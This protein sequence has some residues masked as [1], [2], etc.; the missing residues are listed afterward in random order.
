VDQTAYIGVGANEGDRVS[1]CRRG[2]SEVSRL[3]K[4]RITRVSSLYETEPVGTNKDSPWF[5]NAVIEVSTSHDPKT[6]LNKLLEIEQKFGRVRKEGGGRYQPRPL[7]LDLLL[8]GQEKIQTEDLIVPHPLMH[9]RRFV[10][11]PLNEISPDALH[12]ELNKSAEQLLQELT[13]H[14]AVQELG[15]QAASDLK[16]YPT[17]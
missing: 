11:A 9:Q 12:P 17:A 10:L 8:Y 5:V 6:L 14:Q 1:Q 4:V 2:I 15:D 16:K 7:D 13:A 3:P